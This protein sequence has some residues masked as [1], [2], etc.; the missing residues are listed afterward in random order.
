MGGSVTGTNENSSD[1]DWFRV[2]LEAGTRYQI[3]L[4]GQATGRGTLPNPAVSLRDASATNLA[5]DANSGVGNNSQMIYTPTADGTYTLSVIVLGANGAS[6]AET[7]FP[8]TT[9]T[10]G[11]VDV[12][13]SATGNIENLNDD[14]Y[15]R[16]D[17]EAGKTYQFDLEGVDTSR[18]TRN[19]GNRICGYGQGQSV[20][21]LRCRRQSK[22]GHTS[23]P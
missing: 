18:G 10:S 1:L 20:D 5:S 6:E 8:E 11:R 21:L 22:R 2:D 16:V 12:G 13:A 17:L 14:D 7:D 4:E 9:A 19:R 3:D 23:R 15:F